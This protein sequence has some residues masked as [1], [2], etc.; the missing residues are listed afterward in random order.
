MQH[1]ICCCALWN[2]RDCVTK[3]VFQKIRPVKNISRLTIM[4][5]CP[6]QKRTQLSR[7]IPP[8]RSFPTNWTICSL[9]KGI[10]DNSKLADTNIPGV[11][12]GSICPGC[13]QLSGHLER[14]S[15][16]KFYA[17]GAVLIQWLP[18][19]PHLAPAPVN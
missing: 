10:G 17:R 9:H 2:L 16:D 12:F 6:P 19:S 5:S 4:P 3:L 7:I 11:Y 18:I 15:S 8:V 13:P 1:C 14:G